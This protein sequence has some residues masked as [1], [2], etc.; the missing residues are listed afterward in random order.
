MCFAA[1]PLQNE[2]GIID[3]REFV[4]S[5]SVVCRPSKTLETIQLAFKA[6][7]SFLLHRCF[8]EKNKV[9]CNLI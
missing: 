4:I 8:Y 9:T 2:E 1:F 5:L 7:S 6:S 3:L